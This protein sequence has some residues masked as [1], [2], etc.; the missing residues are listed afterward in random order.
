MTEETVRHI[1]E[2][3]R[4]DSLTM[5]APSKGGEVKIYFNAARPEEINSLI[6]TAFAARAYAASKRVP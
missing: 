5:G 1:H 6:D 2:N 4:P 3:N